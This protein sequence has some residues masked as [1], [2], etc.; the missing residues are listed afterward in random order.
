M[1]LHS[2]QEVS[3]VER[4]EN[5]TSPQRIPDVD[6]LDDAHLAALQDNPEKPEKPSY[7]TIL[8]VFVSLPTLRKREVTKC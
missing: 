8:A 6:L 7:S 1:N 2:K 3:E 5:A 4:I